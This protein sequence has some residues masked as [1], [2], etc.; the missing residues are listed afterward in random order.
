MKTN[1]THAANQLKNAEMASA[2]DK[3]LLT[4]LRIDL[5]VR[6]KLRFYIMEVKNDK[7]LLMRILKE[8]QNFSKVFSI[9]F[10]ANF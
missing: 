5:L 7:T 1:I 6:V 3:K 9:N 8:R 4:L 10:E 2:S